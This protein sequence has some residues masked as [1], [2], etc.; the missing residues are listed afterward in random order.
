MKKKIISLVVCLAMMLSLMSFS[1]TASADANFSGSGTQADP[2]L[3]QTKS[4]LTTLATL[5][6]AAAT[7]EYASKYYKLTADIDMTGGNYE[8]I[9]RANGDANTPSGAAF[10]GTLDGDGHIISNITLNPHYGYAFTYGLIGYLG[11][12]GTVKNLGVENIRLNGDSGQR[13]RI[14]GI[15]GIIGSSITIEN[16]YVRTAYF[17]A[18]T[19]QPTYVGGIAGYA[20]GS[21]GNISNCYSIGL[22]FTLGNSNNSAGIIGGV[23]SGY[24]ATNCYTTNGRTQAS[25]SGTYMTVTKCYDAN[26]QAGALANATVANLG[27]AFKADI[28][29]KNG[30]RPLLSWED[31]GKS[32]DGSG[33]E[34][35]PYL[36]GTPADL[37]KLSTITNTAS[38]AAAYADK[39]YRLTADIDLTDVSY[40]PISRATSLTT[41]QGAAFTGTLDGNY[42]IIKNISFANLATYGNTYGIIGYLGAGGTVKNLGVENMTVNGSNAQR[43]CI[44]GVAGTI[45]SSVNIDNCYVRNMTVNATTDQA[46]FC[47]GIAGYAAGSLG[48]ISNCYSIG[49]TFTLTN[50]TNSAGIIG[51]VTA[52]YTAANCYTT[53]GRT[54]VSRTGAY[55]TVTH[56]YDANG[57]AGALADATASNLGD[58]FKAD[59]NY[60]NGGY[61]LLSWEDPGIA[62]FEGRG[63]EADPFLISTAEDLTRLATLTN[64]ISTAVFAT[65]YYKLTND[66]NMTAVAYTPISRA[67][68]MSAPSGAAFT[69]T[70]DGDGHIISNISFGNLA[71]YGNTYGIIGYLGE[72]GTV[73]NLGVE[74]ITVNSGASNRVCIGGI[75]GSMG[76]QAAIQNC[77]VRGMTVTSTVVGHDDKGNLTDFPYVGGIAGRTLG[78]SGTITSCYTKDLSYN[79]AENR[80]SGGILGSCGSADYS[81][82]NCYTRSSTLQGRVSGTNSQMQ[83]YNCYAFADRHNAT[84]ANLGLSFIADLDSINGGTP[85]LVWE[86]EKRHSDAKKSSV[87]V[88]MTGEGFVDFF[89]STVDS[90]LAEMDPFGNISVYSGQGLGFT[91]IANDGDV[92][93]RVNYNGKSLVPDTD[94]RYTFEFDSSEALNVTFT[95]PT[96][97]DIT[98][99][100][101]NQGSDTNDGTQMAPLKTVQAAVLATRAVTGD[102][103]INLADGEYLLENTIILEDCDDNIKFNAYQ[104]GKVSFNGGKS[105]SKDLFRE[106]S[107]DED[108]LVANLSEAGITNF[109]KIKSFGYGSYPDSLDDGYN[110]ILTIDGEYQILARSNGYLSASEIVS[111]SDNKDNLS[112]KTTGV[113]ATKWQNEKYM[114]VY[115]YFAN[116]WADLSAGAAVAADGTISLNCPSA[117]GADTNH[118]RFFVFNAYSELDTKGEYYIDTNAGML[119]IYKPDN[120]NNVETIFFAA[121]DKP[122]V[123]VNNAANVMFNGI[124][125]TNTNSYGLKASNASGIS[126]EGCEFSGIGKDAIYITASSYAN[127]ASNKIKDIG[128]EGIRY[129]NSGNRDALTSSGTEISN[130]EISNV[131]N[132]RHAGSYAID[133]TNTVGVLVDGNKLHNLPHGAII[134]NTCNDSIMQYNQ[135]YRTN[136]DVSDSGAIYSGRDWTTRGNVI[137]YNYIHDIANSLSADVQAVYLDDA[138]SATTVQYNVFCRVPNVVKIGGGRNNIVSNNLIIDST[139]WFSADE[140]L[141]RDAYSSIYETIQDRYDDVTVTSAAWSKYPNISGIMQDNPQRAKYNCI[142][143]NVKYNSNSYISNPLDAFLTSGYNT[144]NNNEN[145]SSNFLLDYKNDEF[146]LSNTAGSINTAAYNYIKD[147][148]FEEIGFTV[149]AVKVNSFDLADEGTNLTASISVNNYT[150]SAQYLQLLIAQYD[151]DNKLISAARKA[152]NNI[153][154]GAEATDSLTATKD[155]NATEFK[156]FLWTKDFEPLCENK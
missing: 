50:S 68:S 54:Q 114:G 1:I 151:S 41:A 72:G 34:D 46:T 74:N 96:A 11:D 147:I 55:M 120:W 5:T 87:T 103:T 65:R 62:S 154:A 36:I 106:S 20:A 71:T 88:N 125:F 3:I 139:Y 148:P 130:N 44:G 145:I 23:T 142:Q 79:L 48:N 83:V 81:A 37:T 117:Y 141:T 108:I 94:G 116:A 149:N 115:G 98:L 19:T 76:N 124:T 16:C 122:I 143:Y 12:C 8:P 109:G 45:N 136:L 26:G 52:G 128:V 24:T 70:F 91:L 60:K 17:R 51:G 119:Y 104:G 2:F 92:V 153:A 126:I 80:Y 99:Y 28:N 32:F 67:T 69:G 110:P 133:I 112:F 56:C 25:R 63:T 138:H 29:S 111:G 131:G 150:G 135:I 6:N 57:Q 89:S 75:V 95:T 113:D 33:T 38:S 137:R 35:D 86:Y 15:A 84:T 152:I 123:T 49:L 53:S 42:H 61:P 21:S 107:E 85:V 7:K 129:I 66:I 43:L 64:T 9:S 78:Q 121:S 97:G 100:V 101:S 40:T 73:K 18:T 156:A 118:T 77:Y 144:V 59:T 4:D 10:T 132:Q 90:S 134:Y 105:V 31:I 93:T 82:A 39:Y 27:A 58:A 22:T 155:A 127:I 30:G 146:A 102:K 13:L 140:R 14:G 47:G